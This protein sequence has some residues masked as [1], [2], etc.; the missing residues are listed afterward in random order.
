MELDTWR[1]QIYIGLIQ[2]Y[3]PK[4]SSHIFRETW[5][6]IHRKI[7]R[8]QFEFWILVGQ[9]STDEDIFEMGTCGL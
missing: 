8:P 2:L 6:H 9:A 1:H 4:R 7:F 5:R 3:V